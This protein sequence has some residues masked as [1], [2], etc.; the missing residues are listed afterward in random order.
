VAAAGG[1]E[2]HHAIL[3]GALINNERHDMLAS[4]RVTTTSPKF[5]CATIGGALAFFV[6]C[7]MSGCGAGSGEGSGTAGTSGAGR[8]GTTGAAGTGQAGT[9]QA[10]T[11]GSAGTTGNAG[12]SGNAGTTGA[13]GSGPG[14]GGRGGDAV[15]GR[16]GAGGDAGGA[17]AAGRAGGAG[18]GT[19]GRGGA[20]GTGPAGAG[21]RAGAGGGSAGA[22]G[23]G[24]GGAG[25][26]G[27]GA[28]MPSAGCGKAPT[29]KNSPTTTINYN[30]ITSSGMSR[31][32]I[33]RYPSNYD[34]T[35]PYRLILAYHWNTGSAAQ[36]FD[37]NQES[38]K[39]Y[40]TQ[41]PFYGLWNLSNNSTI[42]IA[43]DGLNA[44]WANSGG[45]DVVLTDDI[46]K[47]VEDDLCIDK[48]RVFANGFS[49]GAGMSFALACARPDVFRAV[50]IYSGGQLSGCSGGTS[51]VA[52]YAT[53]GLD[54]GTLQISGGR[55]MRDKFVKNNGCTAMSPPE[56]ANNSGSHI[57]TSY[58]GCSAGHP[59]R[60]CAFD[61]S[62]GHDPSP[63]DPGQSMT[64]NPAEAWMFFTQ[65]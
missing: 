5:I 51:P 62:N 60:W 48:S 15:A 52:Y 35:H 22:G 56:P 47:Q 6:G 17:G 1:L 2:L 65:F 58:Q 46:L 16:G 20:A 42:F 34:N 7:A 31:R 41:S 30:N 55:T 39:C 13:A 18:T 23:A 3:S 12:T 53:H 40:T 8:G 9:S 32:Y 11:S 43:P 61:G 14:A 27:S 24:G 21:G 38:I 37:C 64:W 10:G 36:V 50:G 33:L 57:C 44:G 45:Q 28:A 63:K 49:Y 4:T 59:V 29:L 54:D 19:G 25:A 26:G